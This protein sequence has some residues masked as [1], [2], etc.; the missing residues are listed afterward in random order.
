LAA[1]GDVCVHCQKEIPMTAPHRYRL[2]HRALAAIAA[3]ALGT[4]LAIAFAAPASAAAINVSTEAELA[5]ALAD[6]STTSV[7]LLQSITV[8]AATLE[9][10]A[11]SVQLNLFGFTLT[12]YNFTV[13]SGSALT[14]I[15]STGTTGTLIADASALTNDAG[16]QVPAGASLDIK[17]GTV[18][19][20][21]GLA[22]AGIGGPQFFVAAGAITVDGGTVTANGG[23]FG[24]G[25]GGGRGEPATTVT[26]NGGTV[27]A[28]GG[29][30]AGDGAAGIGS[31]SDMNG[32]AAGTIN[33][34]GGNVTANGG[35]GPTTSGAGIGGG[36]VD[37][38][39]GHVTITAGTVHANGGS[40]SPNFGSAAIGGSDGGAG[41]SLDIQGG[42]VTAN[43]GLDS[44]GIGGSD[45][46][47]ATVTVEGGTI[48][49]TGGFGGAGIGGGYNAAGGT[50][51][52]NGGSITATSGFG[53]AGIGGG[54]NNNTGVGGA[55]ADVTID[56]GASVTA[57]STSAG[58]T[59]TSAIG[60]GGSSAV[61]GS[62]VVGGTLTAS[63]EL[64]V[65][66]GFDATIESTGILQGAGAVNGA[67]NIINHGII[68][69][70]SVT[71]VLDTAGGLNITDHDYLVTFDGND[72][73][74]TPLSTPV[75]LYATTFASGNRTMPTVT[76]TDWALSSWNA[77]SNGSGTTFGTT[78]AVSANRTVYAQWA[79]ES[80]V[81]TPS[82][83]TVVAGDELTFTV[84]AFTP[85]DVSLGDFTSQVDFTSDD[86][87]DVAS[88]IDP[89]TFG[90]IDA[91][92][93]TFTATL[94]SD[95]TVVGTVQ[96]TVTPNLA[97]I[98]TLTLTPSQTIVQQGGTVTFITSGTDIFGNPLGNASSS[99]T[100]TSNFAVDQISGNSITFPH[101]ST[102]VITTT[103]GGVTA[104]VDIT[105][106]PVL[107]LTGVEAIPTIA[108][109]VAML[110]SGVV[111]LAFYFFRRRRTA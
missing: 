76:R 20:T 35:V 41:G 10:S 7:T 108:M 78:S 88:P 33:I 64:I 104:T 51:T 54:Y 68:K 50:F 19:A 102:H 93:H 62:L 1:S 24:A 72:A 80:L 37:A 28:N 106:D 87:D 66:G 94:K 75:R 42:T 103:L 84:E 48:T 30:G 82:A 101:A 34:N 15:D 13:D 60:G 58:L 9:M 44:A 36:S 79:K 69:N 89:T 92:T 39:G 18:T 99:A 97:I 49:A 57:S 4:G 98:G 22:G 31:G 73:S 47:G 6:P 46:A 61:F 83:P 25:I 85:G 95:P 56:V 90:F 109:G 38:P 32:V 14:I 110:V 96:I 111:L 105:V 16:I 17:S 59:G 29:G 5:T 70:T 53:A 77:A 71:D 81:I 107:G 55:G 74:A 86:P 52:A 11:P 63:S 40:S 45:S 65:A 91:G 2:A 27:T 43:G 23:G 21:G 3:L 8:A 26:I 100:L 12:T 67:G